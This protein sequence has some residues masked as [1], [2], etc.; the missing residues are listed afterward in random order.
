VNYQLIPDSQSQDF[1]KSPCPGH[2]PEL[3]SSTRVY[4]RP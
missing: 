4:L 1:H 3:A 2:R